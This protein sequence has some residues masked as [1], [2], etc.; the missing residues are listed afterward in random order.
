MMA[1]RLRDHQTLT[2]GLT[3]TEQLLLAGVARLLESAHEG[4]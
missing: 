3:E 1:K 4:Q 2:S